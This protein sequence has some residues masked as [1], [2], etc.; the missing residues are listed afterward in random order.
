METKM[1]LQVRNMLA[2]AQNLRGLLMIHSSRHS[3][4]VIVVKVDTAVLGHIL[5][6]SDKFSIKS[7]N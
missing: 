2:W 3:F 1:M 4:A 5:S 6:S 7:S